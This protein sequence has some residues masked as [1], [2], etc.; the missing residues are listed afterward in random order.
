[1]SDTGELLCEY[2][3]ASKMPDGLRCLFEDW[4]QRGKCRVVQWFG[5]Y[6]GQVGAPTRGRSLG[7]RVGRRDEVR[8]GH[9][10]STAL[11]PLVFADKTG[12][13]YNKLETLA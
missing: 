1:M 12:A 13:Q 10:V 11:F 4:Q 8:E 2:R 9:V 5:L 7:Y 6:Y 3:D